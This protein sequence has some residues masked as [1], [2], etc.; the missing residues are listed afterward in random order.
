MQRRAG[1]YILQQGLRTTVKRKCLEMI[2]GF[3]P[4]LMLEAGAMCKCVRRKKKKSQNSQEEGGEEVK[5]PLT[6]IV[7][8]RKRNCAKMWKLRKLKGKIH[9]VNKSQKNL[10]IFKVSYRKFSINDLRTKQSKS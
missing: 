2:L 1:G 8:S 5:K 9:K 4:E 3:E 6:Q 10:G 7:N